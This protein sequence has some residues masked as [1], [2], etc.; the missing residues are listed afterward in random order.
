LL[1]SASELGRYAAPGKYTKLMAVIIT[2]EVDGPGA[3]SLAHHVSL[4]NCVDVAHRGLEVWQPGHDQWSGAWADLRMILVQ[5]L[6]AVIVGQL[7]GVVG[8]VGGVLDE[9]TRGFGGSPGLM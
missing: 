8:C 9:A 1:I 6:W 4:R 5:E 2:A 7:F 3:V